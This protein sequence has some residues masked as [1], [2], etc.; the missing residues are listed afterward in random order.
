MTGT[1]EGS[2]AELQTLC[3]TLRVTVMCQT[4]GTLL[5]AGIFVVEWSRKDE[6]KEEGCR[7]K[8]KNVHKGVRAPG[9]PS[10]WWE[11]GVWRNGG[12]RMWQKINRENR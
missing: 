4:D 9:V 11:Y 3:V 5:K 6:Q 1:A 7:G 8:S 2:T 10:G 12:L